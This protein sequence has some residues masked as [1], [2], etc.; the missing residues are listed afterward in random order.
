MAHYAE[1]ASKYPTINKEYLP[2]AIND[3]G[4]IHGSTLHTRNTK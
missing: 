2:A 1:Q 3:M 4:V